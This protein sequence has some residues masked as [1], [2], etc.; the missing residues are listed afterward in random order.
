VYQWAGRS[1]VG[2]ALIGCSGAA[3]APVT[4][5][6]LPPPPSPSGTPTLT[7]A[8]VVS[9]LSNPWDVAVLPDGSLLYTERCR[10]LAI[11]RPDGSTLR[12][13]G[14][15]G[16]TLVAPDLVCEGQSGV[17]GVALDPA[18]AT[19]RRVYLYMASGQASA[20]RSNRVVRLEL[21]P[22][23][24]RVVARD[25]LITDIPYKQAANGVG[26]AGMHSGG[27][28]R[29]GPDGFLY[30]ATGDN[31]SA[32]LP[33]HPT[34]LGGKVLRV[35]SDGRAASGNNAPANFDSRIFSYGHR[36]VQGIAF[37][38]GTREPWVAEHGPNHSDEVTRLVAG[39]NAG[40][41]PQNRPGLNCPSS[42]C[43]YAGNATTMP[44]TDLGRFPSAM[45]PAWTNNGLSQGVGPADFLVG[46]AW[47]DWNGRLAVGVMR[48]QQLVVLAVGSTGLVSGSVVADLPAV[49][50]RGLT[51][52]P[53]GVLYVVTDTGEIWTVTPGPPA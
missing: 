6:V 5:P 25:D 19:N 32:V 3:D 28:L 15:A 30:V 45:P 39:G 8:V 50:F 42:Y 49:R 48:S 21:A 14:T 41:D 9:G 34:L 20:Q 37:H 7:R 46:N 26:A 33:Q 27:R 29:F 10:G 1:V 16:S 11:R 24:S 13:F 38:P 44:M 12:L 40:W 52:G 51:L 43:G 53:G 17:L 18:F 36:N 47:R 2:L 31:H 4:P 23:L 22:D 35:T